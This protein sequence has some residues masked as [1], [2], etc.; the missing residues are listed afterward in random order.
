[1]SESRG[2][3]T[4]GS[5]Y[6]K[7]V[8]FSI[9]LLLGNFFQLM[10]NTI[11]SVVVGNAVGKTAL[12]AVGASTPIINFMIA[13]FMG[14]SSGAGVVVSRHFGARR[15]EE[16]S[17]AVHTFILFSILFGLALSVIGVLIARP[18][19]RWMSTPDDTIDQA[20]RYLQI[21]FAGN[22]FV[23]VYN[24]GTGILQSTGDSRNPLYFLVAT[25]I[26][27]IFLDL[28]FVVVLKMGVA[29][30]ALATILCQAAAAFLV[31]AVMMRTDKAIRLIPAKLKI[32]GRQLSQI[33]QIGIPAG[34]QGMV[35]SVSNVIVMAYINGFGSA[36][37]A[38]FTSANKFDNFLGLPVNSFALACTTFVGQNLGARQYDRVRR[39][40][41]A[42]LILSIAT[43]AVLGVAVLLFAP[44]CIGFFSKDPEVIEVGSRCIR[45][46]CPF[47]FA[48]CIHQVCSGA[49]R[50]SGR[51]SIPMITSIVSFVVIRQIFLAVVLKLT[52][53]I[54][55]VAYGYSFT[56]CL[57]AVLTAGYYVFSGWLAKEEA[58]GASRS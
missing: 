1:M 34:M 6:K 48:L 8:L 28:L 26:L 17:S 5:I 9:P 33:V 45:C 19:L 36:S 25:S 55:V 3:M 41:R 38:G 23:T 20:A 46:M 16:V 14:L 21:Y 12:A 42:S 27:N 22:V 49:L 44:Q 29:G 10:Y 43:V 32:D 37:V 4:S 7:I 54:S 35:V 53:D 56:W 30:A 50:A 18:A 57:A 24:G 2:L 58:G 39:G 47:Y 15:N 52:R 11:D 40:V 31:L 51:S 13:F